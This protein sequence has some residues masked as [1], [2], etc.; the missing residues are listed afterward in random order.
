MRLFLYKFL[1]KS[2]EYLILIL[3]DYDNASLRGIISTKML[4]TI[5]LAIVL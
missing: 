5:Q 1:E 4:F 2:N 3:T